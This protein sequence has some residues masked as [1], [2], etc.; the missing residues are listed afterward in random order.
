MIRLDFELVRPALSAEGRDAI[1]R[2][3]DLV[4]VDPDRVIWRARFRIG[5]FG[6]LRPSFA[7]RARHVRPFLAWCLAPV[8]KIAEPRDLT[9]SES[10]ETTE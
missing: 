10:E 3:I 8:P 1:A 9:I 5:P 6:L 2:V 4:D 7:V